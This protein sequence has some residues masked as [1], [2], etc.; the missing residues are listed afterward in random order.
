MNRITP[1]LAAMCVSSALVGCSNTNNDNASASTETGSESLSGKVA[2]GYLAGATVCLDLNDNQECDADEPSTTSTS[3]G[4]YT[5]EGATAEQLASAAILVEIVVGETIDEDNPGVAID[6][7][8][9]L[10]APAGYNFVSPLTTM[11]QNEVRESGLTPDEAKASVQ[12]KLGTEIDLADDYV[13]GSSDETNGAE[14]ARLHKVAQVTRVVM[15]NNIE[16]V[17]Q[18][19]DGTG[20]AFEDLLSLIVKQ[21]VAALDTISAQVD[22]AGESFDPDDVVSSG[23]VDGAN[24]DTATINDDLAEREA[25][26]SATDVSIAEVLTSGDSLHF[27]ESDEYDQGVVDFF[28]GTVSADSSNNVTI[29]RSIY[30][31]S[32]ESW[33]ADS[34][35][36]ADTYQDC[37]LDSGAWNCVS[38]SSE[39]IT[40]SGD[41]VIVK[42]GG[43]DASKE[44]ITGIS[45]DLTGKRIASFAD[46]ERY[47]YV[48]DPAATFSEGATG[49]RL[50]FVR[51]SAIHVIFNDNVESVSECWDGS[52]S[53][54][55][56]FSPTDTWC[57]NVFLRT[58][59]GNYETDGDAATTLSQ[60]VSSTAA[61]NPNDPSDIKGT[62][63]YG[64][65]ISIMA[66]FVSGGVANY[67][68]VDYRE[69]STTS[70]STKYT[71]TWAQNTVDTKVVMQFT[72]PAILIS[73]GDLDDDEKTQF[74]TVHDGYVRRGGIIPA[75]S[76]NDNQWVFN[77]SAR[78]Q[79]K[80]AFDYSLLTDLEPCSTGDIE[81]GEDQSGIATGGTLSD[82]TSAAEA[83]S[84]SSFVS[85]D[86]TGQTFVSDFGVF[87]FKA[88]G[89]GVF[90]G[91]VGGEEDSVLDFTWAINSAG[92][93]VINT[94]NTQKGETTFLRLTMAKIEVNARQISLK[95]FS[96]E[97]GTSAAVDQAVGEVYGE[98]WAIK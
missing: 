22:A 88:A 17:K 28:Y 38:D 21:V 59:D 32:T 86:L 12:T 94:S 19:T 90:V 9:T 43:L 62:E 72:L 36:N 37:I 92:H 61:S 84:A 74:F 4:A 98:V 24:V 79:I 87:N 42:R 91:E 45:V 83:C 2:D 10:T 71:G 44:V 48:L 68:L 34:E 14:F 70:L 93:V 85:A 18:L 15:Q 27:F 47:E 69:G 60:L 3:G 80:A 33:D 78:D 20:V 23:G 51:D 95:T 46:D 77:N 50:S 82:F 56:P 5:L 65:D 11:V 76:S 52:A 81:E 29:T 96:Q 73:K 8:Y 64:R 40:V 31:S 30:N 1:L 63:L 53:S 57:N 54:E 26:R 35:D 13:A 41:S 97:A 89:A 25:K 66:E 6:R 16:T 75:G 39:T 7:T 58:G 49:Y 67:Y 55:G